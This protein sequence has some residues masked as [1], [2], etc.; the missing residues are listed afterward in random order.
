M[1]LN[2]LRSTPV[3]QLDF[4]GLLQ[5]GDGILFGQACSE[6]L[7]LTE[8][9]AAQA[10]EITARS[11]RLQ[12]FLGG[13]Y[14]GIF[15]PALAEH[16]DFSSYG[17]FGGGA[18]LA[19]ASKLQII[20]AHYSQLPRLFASGSIRADLV[21]L[22][23]APPNTAGR[24]SLGPANDF[25]LA[26]ARGARVV[27]A[28]V[29][30]RAPWTYGAEVPDDLRIDH[31]VH[32]DRDLVSIP[33][34]EPNATAM[35]IA[36]NVAELVPMG[37][38]LQMGI[39]SIMSAI[40]RELRGH[41]DLGVHT[42][43]IGDGIADLIELGVVSNRLK[44][45]DARFAVGGS[46]FGTARLLRFA[47]RNPAIRLLETRDTH[48]PAA[49]ARLPA[50]HAINSAIEVDLTGQ[51]NGEVSAG[52]YI[53]AV[54][55]QIDFVRAAA[56]SDGGRSVIA[57]P[58]TAKRDSISR[59]V[60]ALS[61]VPVTTPRSDVDCVVTEWGCA[62]LRGLSLAARASAMVRVAHPNFREQLSR[63]ARD[64]H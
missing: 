30:A 36:R 22:Q 44:P 40:C 56:N 9:L 37:A 38:T 59:I 50:F 52:R 35:D 29:N 32:S 39:G 26:A 20:P 51:V 15:T 41:R 64:V 34:D 17:A 11:G 55:G 43:I 19:A 25:L 2:R 61:G 7:S 48:G 23:V 63:A 1:A 47:H 54:G 16:F 3:G 21:L 4:S 31:V 6:A 13:S 18:E 57:L 42:G 60:P 62:H 53:G 27:V 33:T 24:Y 49:L 10:S 14:S 46:L 58:S 5:P 45:S 12:V 8:R 28:E